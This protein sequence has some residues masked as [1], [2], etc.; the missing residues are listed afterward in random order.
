MLDHSQGK[1][2]DEFPWRYFIHF[3]RW[4]AKKSAHMPK[5]VLL[6][7]LMALS[8]YTPTVNSRYRTEHIYRTGWIFLHC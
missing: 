1:V 3:R 8:S 6:L 7:L 2:R 4:A 5:I